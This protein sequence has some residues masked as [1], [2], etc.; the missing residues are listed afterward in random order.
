VKGFRSEC[1]W[2]IVKPELS[3]QRSAAKVWRQRS[4]LLRSLSKRLIEPGKFPERWP[5]ANRAREKSHE[6]YFYRVT[7]EGDTLRKSGRKVVKK[8]ENVT[9]K[10]TKSVAA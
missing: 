2:P 7:V 1:E 3:Y 4:A 6:K 9:V 8:T 5:T 10:V